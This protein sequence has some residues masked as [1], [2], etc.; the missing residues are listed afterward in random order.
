MPTLDLQDECMSAICQ[1]IVLLID[2]YKKNTNI[3]FPNFMGFMGCKCLPWSIPSPCTILNQIFRK[4]GLLCMQAAIPP[5]LRRRAV[6]R[7]FFTTHIY[8]F[9]SYKTIFTWIYGSKNQT[10]ILT[11]LGRPAPPSFKPFHFWRNTRDF[12]I[13]GKLWIHGH[14]IYIQATEFNFISRI[15][16]L[17]MW[18]Y[19]PRKPKQQCNPKIH[20]E[21]H[22]KQY[23]SKL[24]IQ[25]NPFAK[26]VYHKQ[27]HQMRW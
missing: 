10:R 12:E 17:H 18:F 14:V 24:N 1:W 16:V 27:T 13:P 5:A 8:V 22:E 9:E 15:R 20:V 3:Y 23:A 19:F 7:F 25:Q 26:V 11:F 2:K 21:L 6:P 4:S